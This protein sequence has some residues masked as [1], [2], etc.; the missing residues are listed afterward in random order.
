MLCSLISSFSGAKPASG[1]GTIKW[2]DG[3]GP[4]FRIRVQLVSS[5]LNQD[6]SLATFFKVFP[7]EKELRRA[8]GQS[9]LLLEEALLGMREV[10]VTASVRFLAPVLDH[11]VGLLSKRSS[12]IAR[13]VAFLAMTHLISKVANSRD[14]GSGQYL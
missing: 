8:G 14:T 10:G 9:R 11:I 1:K 7:N 2:R 4:A 6:P 12:P 13:Q 5:V 3:G